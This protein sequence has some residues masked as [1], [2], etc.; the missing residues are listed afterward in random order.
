MYPILRDDA[1]L[2]TFHNQGSEEMHYYA[3]NAAGDRIEINHQ[4]LEA[5]LHADGTH[6]LDLPV[7]GEA[8]ISEL[9][10]KGIIQTSRLSHDDS[11]DSSFILIPFREHSPKRNKI[12]KLINAVLPFVSIL[13]FA[14]GIYCKATSSLPKGDDSN[15]FILLISAYLLSTAFHELGHMIAGFAY[16]YRMTELGVRLYHYV[17]LTVYVGY[18]D[19]MKNTTKKEQLQFTLAGAEGE[20]VFAGIALLVSALYAPLSCTAFVVA[21]MTLGI[22]IF[23]LIPMA[24]SDGEETLSLLLNVPSIYNIADEYVAAKGKGKELTH[25][26]P[27]GF[28]RRCFLKFIYHADKL[29]WLLPLLFIAGALVYLAVLFLG[30]DSVTISWD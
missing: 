12:C 10:S 15:V 19:N 13:T 9:K 6:P 30:A 27:K 16:G 22:M 26:G 7:N 14:L 23:N 2:G 28:L 18:E 11:G 4:T 5:L 24:D 8:I 29:L 17:P 21:L 1:S 25:S 3:K 20:L